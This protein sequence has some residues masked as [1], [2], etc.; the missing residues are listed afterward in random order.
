MV[1]VVFFHLLNTNNLIRFYQSEKLQMAKIKNTA[2]DR[3]R[4]RTVHN[5]IVVNA[6][7]RDPNVVKKHS[8]PGL[9]FDGMMKD[10]DEHVLRFLVDTDH[11]RGGFRGELNKDFDCVNALGEETGTPEGV[12]NA[13]MM[14][15]A[16]S[17]KDLQ[18]YTLQD[19]TEMYFGTKSDSK[20]PKM[21]DLLEQKQMELQD[22][23]YQKHQASN[24][25]NPARGKEINIVRTGANP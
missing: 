23:Y 4:A 18:Q 24:K 9:P 20:N 6:T 25:G 10:G 1:P 14:A 2:L 12:I 21:A 3:L 19:D 22:S 7:T 13:E 15:Q 8:M 5:F 11:Y 17:L 16:L